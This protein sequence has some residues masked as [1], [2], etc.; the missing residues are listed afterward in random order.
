MYAGLVG[1]L[2]RWVIA[3]LNDGRVSRVVWWF[4]TDATFD[5]AGTSTWSGR[6]TGREEIGEWLQRF[7]DTGLRLEVLDVVVSGGPWNMRVAIR[8]RDR[9]VDG[10]GSVV[11][12]NEGVLYERVR[13]GRITHHES[14]E[15]TERVTRFDEYLR[16]APP[17]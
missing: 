12:E 4:A 2:L 6:R 13:W 16:S 3:Q 8:F 11:Y 14:H 17:S 15:D 5:F 1:R 7:A 10:S 9:L